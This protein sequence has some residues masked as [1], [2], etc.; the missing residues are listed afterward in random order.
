L[1]KV[2]SRDQAAKALEAFMMATYGALFRYI[3]DQ[4]NSSITF[5]PNSDTSA[6]SSSAIRILDIFGFESFAV[7]S[8]EQLCINYC[9]ETLQSQFNQ[10]VFK[11]EQQEY[12]REGIEWS[13]ID[14]PDN[15]E[16]LDLIEK[17]RTGIISIL[18]EQCRLTK[19][20]DQ[21]FVLWQ[22]HMKYA[23]TI[24]VSSGRIV[25]RRS[26]ASRSNTMQVLLNITQ[27]HSSQRIRTTSPRKLPTYCFHR[28][29][30]FCKISVRCFRHPRRHQVRRRLGRWA[31][32]I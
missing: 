5:E 21:S 27:N 17:K 10:Y 12:E 4:I 31:V 2:L 9:N 8:F 23:R 20:T 1:R 16:V 15:Q 6:S 28:R 14:F 30:P 19:C 13:F 3:V 29:D 25:P 7:N 11:L 32:H 26:V 22:R 24:L 18:D